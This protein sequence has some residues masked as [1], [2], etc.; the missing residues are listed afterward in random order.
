MPFQGELMINHRL[1]ARIAVPATAAALLGAL[2]TPSHARVPQVGIPPSGQCSSDSGPA[3]E[4][5]LEK[6]MTLAVAGSDLYSPVPVLSR[7]RLAIGFHDR[8][9]GTTCYYNADRQFKTASIVKVLIAVALEWK[10]QE[11]LRPVDPDTAAKMRTMITST[12]G[13]GPYGNAST[14]AAAEL[15]RIVHHDDEHRV[16]YLGEVIDRIGLRGTVPDG[17]N[18]FGTT[19]TTARDQ[20]ALFKFLTSPNEEFLGRNR[21][22]HVLELLVEAATKYGWGT[23]N[24]AP[25]GATTANK[26]GYDKLGGRPVSP[27]PWVPKKASDI[28]TAYH[29]NAVGA[30]YGGAGGGNYD[31]QMAVL[32]D[33]NNPVS[34]QLRINAV[35]SAFNKAMARG[36]PVPRTGAATTTPGPPGRAT[37]RP[38][39]PPVQPPAKP[40][41]I[42]FEP[43]GK[44]VDNHKGLARSSNKVQQWAC[45]RP[46]DPDTDNQ[47]WSFEWDGDGSGFAKIRNS[48]TGMC[49]DV[50]GHSTDNGAAVVLEQCSNATSWKGTLVHDGDIDHYELRPRSAEGKCLDLPRSS[51]ADGVQLQQWDCV[52]GNH[53]QHLTWSQ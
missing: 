51:K 31:Y 11:E 39:A 19:L 8:S 17:E 32:T 16:P 36:L 28:A 38:S 25:A 4:E 14:G 12:A 35:A 1:R 41:R 3:V 37:L 13:G 30:I 46:G 33:T 49:L 45:A 40:Y 29:T 42:T 24:A 10:A 22:T 6:T 18:E 2:A 15:W 23:H 9:S 52:S 34:G 43:T 20:V 44:C 26:I 50:Q 7:S 27:L 21:R 53:Q 5:S 48:G 47:R